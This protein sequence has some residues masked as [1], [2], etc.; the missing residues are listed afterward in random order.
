[1]GHCSVRA[2]YGSLQCEDT[3]GHCNVRALY[4]SRQCEGTIWV[5]AQCEDTS[6][7]GRCSVRTLVIWVT[8]V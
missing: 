2:L 3:M 7:M 1:M 4:E 8:A 6:Y 5:T